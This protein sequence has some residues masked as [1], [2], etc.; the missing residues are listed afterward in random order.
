MEKACKSASSG[1]QP[2]GDM[3][4]SQQIY[5]AG[6]T[7]IHNVCLTIIKTRVEILQIHHFST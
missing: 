5:E 1:L 6:S 3:Y 7:I 2:T 4:G